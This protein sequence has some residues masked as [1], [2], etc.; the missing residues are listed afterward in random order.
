MGNHEKSIK[1]YMQPENANNF[2]F[3]CKKKEK[4]NIFAPKKNEGPS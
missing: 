4:L 3:L 2:H 1:I